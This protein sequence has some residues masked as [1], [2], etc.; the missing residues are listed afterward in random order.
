MD[1]MIAREVGAKMGPTC[2][3]ILT[4]EALAAPYGLAAARLMAA[5][6]GLGD[7]PHAHLLRVLAT[8]AVF[9]RKEQIEGGDGDPVAPFVECLET[10]AEFLETGVRSIP[11]LGLPH[12]IQEVY[13]SVEDATGNHYGH[14]FSEFERDRYY[15]EPLQLLSR[16]FSRNG[17]HVEAFRGGR[18]L[19]AGCGNGRYT[20]ALRRLGFAEVCGIDVSTVGIADAHT[21]LQESWLSG[22]H[23]Q[24]ASALALPFPEA[25]FDFVFSNGVLH[26]TPDISGGVRELIRVLRHGGTGYLYLIERPGGIFWD[27]I[28]ILRE[29]LAGVSFQF[30]RT[31]F[32][33]LGVPPHRRYY[34]L[35]H[36]MAPINTR[37]TP[38][39]VEAFL[40]SAGASS[41]RRLS[42]GADFDRVERIHRQ[43]PFA[44]LKYGVGE[45]RYFFQ[46]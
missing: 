18:A 31:V 23:F 43:E 28:D 39:A 2:D 19:D 33:L 22:V 17:I 41:W 35:D 13:S 6:R 25:S 21:R 11:G 29:V 20:I 38:E 37:C 32:A 30:A 3:G 9:H 44:A 24:Q 4:L 14:L 26:H 40:G 16:R 46:K 8:Y 27:T 36:I 10:V 1:R 7:D 42:R 45:N 5:A 34:I 12:Q 15:D